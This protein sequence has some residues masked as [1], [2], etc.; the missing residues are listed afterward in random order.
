VFQEFFGLDVAAIC[1][2]GSNV[3]ISFE[4]KQERIIV[5]DDQLET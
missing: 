5:P 4:D 3:R 2:D 1:D